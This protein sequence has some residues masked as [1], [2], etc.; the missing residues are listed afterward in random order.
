MIRKE[1]E[2]IFADGLADSGKVEKLLPHRQLEFANYALMR[3]ESKL[4]GACAGASKILDSGDKRILI[5]DDSPDCCTALFSMLKALGLKQG[6]ERVDLCMSAKDAMMSMVKGIHPEGYPPIYEQT[7]PLILQSHTKTERFI[8]FVREATSK[9]IILDPSAIGLQPYGPDHEC[10]Y[11][12]I[13]VDCE[14]PEMDGYELTRCLRK[15]LEAAGICS[16]EE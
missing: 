3:A 7:S 10:V 15:L 14:L 8:E 12:L 9:D 11:S 6:E 4:A 5:I 16:F 1:F 2:P 13:M